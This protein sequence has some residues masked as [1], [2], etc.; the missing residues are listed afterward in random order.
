[1][2]VYVCVVHL[3]GFSSHYRH[4]SKMHSSLQRMEWTE[5]RST[6]CVYVWVCDGVHVWRCVCVGAHCTLLYPYNDVSVSIGTDSFIGQQ[7]DT[8]SSSLSDE[9]VICT[10][11]PEHSGLLHSTKITANKKPFNAIVTIKM[12]AMQYLNHAFLTGIIM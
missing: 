6:V 11:L 4:R 1:M 9:W 12:C 7:S 2:N 3:R 10:I 5:E 8:T